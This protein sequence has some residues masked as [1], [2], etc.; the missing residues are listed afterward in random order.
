MI[1]RGFRGQSLIVGLMVFATGTFAVAS[2]VHSGVVIAL[3]PVTIDDQL[4]GAMIPEAIIAIVLGI[5]SIAVI[6]RG[7][8][9]RP[10]AWATTL[11]ALLGTL[12]GLTVTV[13]SSRTGDVAYHVAI[14]LVLVVILGLLLSTRGKSN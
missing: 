1:T 13:R 7:A 8:A 3:G 4:N 2:L 14:L 12:F 10:L 6:I 9:G 11:F 5:G